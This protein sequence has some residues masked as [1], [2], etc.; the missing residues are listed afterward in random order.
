M[1]ADVILFWMMAYV[2]CGTFSGVLIAACVTDRPPEAWKF[3]A[4]WSALW[5]PL[6]VLV[7]ILIVMDELRD[8]FRRRRRRC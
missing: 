8:V 2:L 5:A 7:I 3:V 1:N 6:A 4:T